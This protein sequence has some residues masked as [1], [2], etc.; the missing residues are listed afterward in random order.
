MLY[1][2]VLAFCGTGYMI[3]STTIGL[4]L[5]GKL[6][7]IRLFS[8]IW[9]PAGINCDGINFKG[10]LPMRWITKSTMLYVNVLDL[11]CSRN[12]IPGTTVRLPLCGKFIYVRRV[13]RIWL[14][15]IIYTQCV[16]CGR[17]LPICS[18]TM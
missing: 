3:Y 6:I 1:R 4:P 16:Y 14:P 13:S 8:G 18:I 12:H 15:R 7:D 2:N 9:M 5:R 10:N 11:S 17:N